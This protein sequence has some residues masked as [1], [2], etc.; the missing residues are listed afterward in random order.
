[1]VRQSAR[2]SPMILLGLL[3]CLGCSL[4]PRQDWPES[5]DEDYP[6]RCA[7][8]PQGLPPG[9]AASLCLT[10]AR[11]LEQEGLDAEAAREYELARHYQPQVDVAHRL[12][13]VYDRLGNP[14]LA[15]A[16]YERAVEAHPKDADLLNDLG[17]Y[18][19]THGKWTLA[20]QYLRRALEVNPEYP[21]AWTNLGLALAQQ[22]RS[23]ESLEAFKHSV[24]PAEA[25]Y[26]LGFVLAERGKKDEARAAYKEA[27]RLNPGMMAAQAALARLP[28]GDG[29]PVAPPPSER[30][31][32]IAQR[33]PAGGAAPALARVAGT[34]KEAG[35]PAPA[36]PAGPPAKDPRQTAEHLAAVAAAGTDGARPGASPLPTDVADRVP[37]RHWVIPTVGD[38]AGATAEPKDPPASATPGPSSPASPM[39]TGGGS[40][41]ADPAEPCTIRWVPPPPTPQHRLP[42]DLVPCKPPAPR[43]EDRA[44]TP[45]PSAAGDSAAP[46]APS[47][48]S[49]LPEP[50]AKTPPAP[51]MPAGTSP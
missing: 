41:P 32:V 27:V 9:E 51:P 18:H 6:C 43:G 8:D 4:A 13:V 48:E 23:Q 12:A 37:A 26:N 20:E 35:A 31:D 7:A 44:A 17:Y 33:V 36:V 15:A 46:P 40:S 3:G 34:G 42:P 38:S 22:G 30:K 16:E 14:G 28:V 47:T 11:K 1:M 2:L 24:T 45:A 25:Q 49:I 50:S 39:V 10:L 19:Y 29:G 21:R 5:P